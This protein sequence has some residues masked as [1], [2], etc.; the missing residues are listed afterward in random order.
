MS[1]IVMGQFGIIAF[2]SIFCCFMLSRKNISVYETKFKNKELEKELQYY[3]TISESFDQLRKLR[4]DMGNH[5]GILYSLLNLKRTEQAMEYLK[6]VTEKIELSHDISTIDDKLVSI[7]FTEKFQTARKKG[8]AIDHTVVV[9]N[10]FYVLLNQ[11]SDIDK[12]ALFTN[13]LDNSIEAAEQSLKKKLSF[14]IR[15]NSDKIEITCCNSRPP[16]KIVEGTKGIF[17]TKKDKS[18]HGLGTQIIKQVVKR[19]DGVIFNSYTADT[20]TVTIIFERREK[21]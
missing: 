6:S 7:I 3:N 2:I 11:M 16:V 21:P 15:A 8:I 18:S 20:F 14:N 13:I 17:T 4:H 10:F 1:I 19:Y 12:T 9:S 5:F